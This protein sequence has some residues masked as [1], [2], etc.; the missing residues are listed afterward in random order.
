MFYN[1]W[2]SITFGKKGEQMKVSGKGGTGG[3]GGVVLCAGRGWKE[4]LEGFRPNFARKT[5]ESGAPTWTEK[6]E[7]YYRV[8]DKSLKK[9]GKGKVSGPREGA[10]IGGNGRCQRKSRDLTG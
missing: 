6:F 3:F 8:L 7:I 2:P 4:K 5:A 9:G 10:K 1:G